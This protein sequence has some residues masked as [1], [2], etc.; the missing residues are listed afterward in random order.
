MIMNAIL[1]AFATTTAV[2][3]APTPGP[4][5]ACFFI[6]QFALSLEHIENALYQQALE[7]FDDQAFQNAGFPVWVRARFERLATHE[8]EHVQY[9]QEVLSND[10]PKP[11]EY[12]FSFRLKDPLSFVQA[13]MVFESV[14]GSTYITV[15]S[16]LK[17]LNDVVLAGSIGAVESRQVAWVASAALHLEPWN[18]GFETPLGLTGAYT[19]AQPLITSCPWSSCPVPSGVQTNL[20][21]LTLATVTPSPGGHVQVSFGDNDFSTKG[22]QKNGKAQVPE[23]LQGIVYVAVVLGPQGRSGKQLIIVSGFKIAEF[24]FPSFA[25][26][27]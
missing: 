17:Q 18:E 11:C 10:A 8:K 19:L 14:A 6:L 4:A 13:A 15:G 22:G 5:G 23:G 16:M 12:D 25:E 9:L 24:N 1:L 21:A 27:S 26:N 2:I 3:A 20:P 7:K